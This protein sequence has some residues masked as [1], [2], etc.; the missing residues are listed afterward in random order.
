MMKYRNV[1]LN[2][3]NNSI[4]QECADINE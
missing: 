4:Q 3:D 2:V 1:R